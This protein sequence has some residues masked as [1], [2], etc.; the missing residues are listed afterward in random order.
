MPARETDGLDE[1][2]VLG[3]WV[4]LGLD[5]NVWRLLSQAVDQNSDG[6]LTVNE[7]KKGLTAEGEQDER[8]D[9]SEMIRVLNKIMPKPLDAES[10]SHIKGPL[11]IPHK[12][13]RKFTVELVDPGTPI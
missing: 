2:V 7:F 9:N 3:L 5:R 13:L 11:S 8:P 4:D 6:T 12:T 10:E 1:L